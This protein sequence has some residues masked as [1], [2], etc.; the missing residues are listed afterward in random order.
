MQT[1][2]LC[3]PSCK[4]KQIKCTRTTNGHCLSAACFRVW[5]NGTRLVSIQLK[6]ITK[7]IH[8]FIFFGE[9]WFHHSVV[10]L[11]KFSVFFRLRNGNRNSSMARATIYLSN[12]NWKSLN[13]AYQ[14]YI[15]KNK[16][17]RARIS[18]L[19]M[20]ERFTLLA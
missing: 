2:L 12:N 19:F 5:F 6:H 8:S 13:F 15:V 9:Q 10:N 20:G 7:N 1:N 3:K 17:Y 16:L 14:I 18:L 11:L 4:R